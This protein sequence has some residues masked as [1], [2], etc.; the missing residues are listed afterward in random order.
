MV[1]VSSGVN[2]HILIINIH[3][4]FFEP[5]FLSV[6][7]KFRSLATTCGGGGGSDGRVSAITKGEIHTVSCVLL[8]VLSL[9]SH[10]QTAWE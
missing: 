1:A 8:T 3:S 7:L 10:S 2:M 5:H 4:V 6:C 9:W